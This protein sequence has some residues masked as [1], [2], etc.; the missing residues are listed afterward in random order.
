MKYASIIIGVII[1]LLIVGL[2]FAFVPRYGGVATVPTGRV[3]TYGYGTAPAAYQ[4]NVLGTTQ[5]VNTNVPMATIPVT[6]QTQL[7]NA[8]YPYPN[9][10]YGTVPSVPVVPVVWY[11]SPN[12]P[13]AYLYGN[14]SY[15]NTTVYPQPSQTQVY[16]YS[17][18]GV[19]NGTANYQ[20]QQQYQYQNGATQ[21][22][23]VWYQ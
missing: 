16:T 22:G 23:G 14:S 7:V 9:N 17:N 21:T 13:T 20:Y 12:A 10:T 3:V 11:T 6:A 19:S 15:S 18:P 8:G 1:L 2:F 5:V 4:A